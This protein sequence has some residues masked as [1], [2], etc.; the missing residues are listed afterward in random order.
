MS[1]P[2]AFAGPPP[3]SPPPPLTPSGEVRRSRAPWLVAA[4]AAVVAVAAMVA[5]VVV[6]VTG[7]DEGGSDAAPRL[8]SEG[9]AE[10]GF[11][12]PEEA[13]TFMIDRLADVEVGEASEAFAVETVVE[14]Y[15][16]EAQA[17][18]LRS[19][20]FTTWLPQSSDGYQR[21]NTDVRRGEVAVEL[22]SLIRSVLAPERD[23]TRTTPLDD[24]LTAEELADELSPEPLSEL[25]VA[26]VD[27]IDRSDAAYLENL[28]Q[29]GAIFG[30]DE[31]RM[32]A[33]L[34]DTA[35]GQV[36][37]GATVVRYGDQWALLS[38]TA[39]ILGTPVVGLEAVT[40][41][42]YLAAVESASGS[43]G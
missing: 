5:L 35:E 12:S 41:E 17:E 13:V 40:E 10:R 8:G 4:L 42:E 30:A 43:A 28:E 36:M 15:S 11:D 6:L 20:M 23:Q 34:L 16:F 14:G 26:R 18:R 31:L 37:G 25:A 33:M 39:P 9:S 7:D 29:Q 32:V 38:L 3:S 22:R 27:A 24:D 2:H 21:I 1:D 19:V